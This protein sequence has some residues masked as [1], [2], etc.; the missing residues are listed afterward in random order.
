MIRFF[1]SAYPSRLFVLFLLALVM[2]IPSLIYSSPVINYGGNN[3][4]HNLIQFL[5]VFWE[6]KL[7]AFILFFLSALVLNATGTKTG[8]TLKNSYLAAFIFILAASSAPFLTHATP[9]LLANLLFILF[10]K[11]V[12]KLQKTNEPVLAAFD[13]GLMLGIATLFFPPL[14]FLF[15]FIWFALIVYRISKWR[16]YVA[17]LTGSLFPYFFLIVISFLLNNPTNLHNDFMSDISLHPGKMMFSS[18]NTAIL[19]GLISIAVLFS[20]LQMYSSM[21]NKNIRTRQHILVSLW[22]LFFVSLFLFFFNKYPE[23]IVILTGPASL[24]LAAYLS[25]LH[26]YKWG[27]RIVGLFIVMI[28]V[29]QLYPLFNV[30]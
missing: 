9:F 4:Y 27:N 13:A 21:G 16:P 14:L 26:N 19:V 22:L 28:F 23:T 11:S 2:W 29:N 15:V 17:A 5:P 12:F 6:R 24:M 1:Q 3:I 8:L 10:L 20:A 7:V 18:V 25:Q 30:A